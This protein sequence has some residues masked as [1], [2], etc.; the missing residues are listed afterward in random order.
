MLIN[1]TQ[2]YLCNYTVTIKQL[3]MGTQIYT[4]KAFKKYQKQQIRAVK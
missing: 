4:Q 1:I 3:K 2:Y